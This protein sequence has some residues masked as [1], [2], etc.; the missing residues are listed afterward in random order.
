MPYRKLLA[1]SADLPHK[2][3]PDHNDAAARTSIA[4]DSAVLAAR[5]WAAHPFLLEASPRSF[6]GVTCQVS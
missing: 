5:E 6:R 1:S 2:A 3:I 4:E